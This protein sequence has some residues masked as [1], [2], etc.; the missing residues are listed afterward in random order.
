M[1]PYRKILT[2]PRKVAFYGYFYARYWLQRIAG[3]RMR[4][5][6]GPGTIC[7]PYGAWK[8]A[9][10]IG[11]DLV[12]SDAPAD[13]GYRF[14]DETTGCREVAFAEHLVVVNGHSLDI[15]KS[16][17]GEV[18]RATL[19]YDC[20][21]DPTTHS[22]PMVDKSELNSAHD[23]VIIEGP[24]QRPDSRRVYQRVLDNEVEPGVVEDL[25][26]SVLAGKIVFALRKRRPIGCRF[27]NASTAVVVDPSTIFSDLELG[28]IAAFARDMRLDIGEI[29][30]VRDRADG[31]IY[32]LDVNP[33]PHSPPDAL[34]GLAGIRCMQ[35][36]AAAF[37]RAWG[38][39]AGECEGT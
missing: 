16:R 14:D 10:L 19:G 2:E 31:R 34:I 5:A 23:G 13:L 33:T 35:Q 11:A 39:K 25:R 30:I 1:V 29:D 21:V 4:I 15:R 24:L 26:V 17:V 22:G 3:R 36:V 9:K 37:L 6:V 8:I 32:M 18:A 38:P 28:Q 20:R 12:A 7:R 27:A